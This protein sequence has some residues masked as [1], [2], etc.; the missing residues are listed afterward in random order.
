MR[1]LCP[2]QN[3][4]VARFV[5]LREDRQDRLYVVDIM[6]VYLPRGTADVKKKSHLFTIISAVCADQDFLRGHQECL[7][8]RVL[9]L[10]LSILQGSEAS[11]WR[12]P[13]HISGRGY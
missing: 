5:V 6:T 11:S 12:G 8:E 4:K 3:A 9:H 1:R 2:K 13:H 7:C 10:L